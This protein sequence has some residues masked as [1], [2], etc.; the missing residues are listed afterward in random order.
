MLEIED[1][2]EAAMQKDLKKKRINACKPFEMVREKFVTYYI[3]EY[4][5]LPVWTDPAINWTFNI[6]LMSQGGTEWWTKEERA[7]IGLAKTIKERK[8]SKTHEEH[9]AKRRIREA[10]A[11]LRKQQADKWEKEANRG[12]V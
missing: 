5:V 7:A 8:I 2:V 10:A 12:Q 9:L 3:D 6:W 11:R 4:G 1:D